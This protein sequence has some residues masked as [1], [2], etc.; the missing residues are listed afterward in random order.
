MVI[1][2]LDRVRN[3]DARNELEMEPLI[4][5]LEQ[6]QLRWFGHLIRMKNDVPVKKVREAKIQQRIARCRPA[7][8]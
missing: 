8:T 3:V 6:G 5:K 2:R 4:D 7:I 1:T